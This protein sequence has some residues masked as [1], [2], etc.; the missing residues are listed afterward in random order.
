MTAPILHLNLKKR[1]FNMVASGEKQEEYREIKP[2][3]Q[4]YFVHGLIKIGGICYSPA[5]VIICFS[6]GYSTDRPQMR[7]KCR[8]LVVRTGRPEWG[9]ET[10]KE[11]FVIQIGERI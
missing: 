7:Y 5:N 1:W 3:W 9:A 11:Y 4:K 2:Y 10:G 6:L 8:G